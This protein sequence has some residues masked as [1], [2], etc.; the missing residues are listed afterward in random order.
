MWVFNRV[1]KDFCGLLTGFS[2]DLCGFYRICGWL[3]SYL[4]F[5][6]IQA[7]VL[8]VRFEDSKVPFFCVG[9]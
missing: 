4:V 9:F 7:F 1:F 5:K 8:F 6:K 2:K 3:S